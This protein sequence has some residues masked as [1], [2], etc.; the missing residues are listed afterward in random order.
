MLLSVVRIFV[1][2][3]LA[4]FLGFLALTVFLDRSDNPNHR[5]D[6]PSYYY[7]YHKDGVPV[8][9]TETPKK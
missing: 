8:I 6:D 3:S 1:G 4:G 7:Q 2:L 5:I 9:P